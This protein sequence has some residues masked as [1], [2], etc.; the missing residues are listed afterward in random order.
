MQVINEENGR[1]NWASLSPQR[2]QWVVFMVGDQEQNVNSDT[3][4]VYF[5]FWASVDT[6]FFPSGLATCVPCTAVRLYCYLCSFRFRFH[7]VL[8]GYLSRFCIRAAL[9]RKLPRTRSRILETDC[10]TS[11]ENCVGSGT[12]LVSPGRLPPTFVQV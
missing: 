10:M 1:N 9:C 11:R 3:V 5:G 7:L 8:V 4:Q 6:P 12:S 2:N